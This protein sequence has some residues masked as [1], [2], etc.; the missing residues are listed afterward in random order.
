MRGTETYS[1]IQLLFGVFNIIAVVAFLRIASP[2]HFD[3]QKT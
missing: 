2:R 1:L 3:V